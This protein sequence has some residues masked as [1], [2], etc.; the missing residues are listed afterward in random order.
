MIEQLRK[1]ISYDPETGKFTRLATLVS[2]GNSGEG[3]IN[4]IGYRVISVGGKRYYAHRLAW[5]LHHGEWPKGRIDHANGD[6][7]DN[8]IANIRVA[9]AAQNVQNRKVRADNKSGYKGVSPNRY[10]WMANIK[11]D[12]KNV[13]LGTYKTPVEAAEVYRAAS[14]KYHGEFSPFVT[15]VA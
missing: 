14:I 13:Y 7:D 15:G 4:T 6:R 2:H 3:G 5:A 8:R 12:K 9:S 10:G 11:V 1:L